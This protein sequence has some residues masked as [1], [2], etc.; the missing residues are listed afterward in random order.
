MAKPDWEEPKD[1]NV[2]VL[3]AC[4]PLSAEKVPGLQWNEL[5]PFLYFGML[6]KAP[7]L[8]TGSALDH[9]I[10]QMFPKKNPVG[11]LIVVSRFLRQSLWA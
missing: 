6:G 8:E 7:K 11:L 1:V 2:L 9:D 4:S 10:S 3:S 5:Y